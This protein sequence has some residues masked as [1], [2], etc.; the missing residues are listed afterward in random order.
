MSS[1]PGMM[2][3]GTDRM[4]WVRSAAEL[5]ESI[6]GALHGTDAAAYINKTITPTA[7]RIWR[8]GEGVH[9]SLVA[10]L[11]DPEL[12]RYLDSMVQRI[13]VVHK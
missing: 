5:N 1:G 3:G 2:K 8:C 11:V 12:R 9:C 6:C 4:V 10:H 7:A 13:R